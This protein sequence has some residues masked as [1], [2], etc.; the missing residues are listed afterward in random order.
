[1]LRWFMMR[2]IYWTPYWLYMAGFILVVSCVWEK[3]REARQRM[4]LFGWF[5]ATALL[6]VLVLW[7]HRLV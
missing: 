6:V 4:G 5:C 2:G 7:G 3:G 1:M